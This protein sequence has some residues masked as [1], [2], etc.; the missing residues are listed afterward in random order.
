MNMTFLRLTLV[1]SIILQQLREPQSQKTNTPFIAGLKTS[2]RTGH[3]HQCRE[4]DSKRHT[5]VR[6]AFFST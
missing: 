4:L 2:V 5:G 6:A 3:Q 1:L